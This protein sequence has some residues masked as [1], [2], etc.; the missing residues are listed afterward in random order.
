MRR[1]AAVAA[2]AM[3]LALSGPVP[4]ASAITEPVVD[5]AALPPDGP[6]APPRPMRPLGNCVE[7]GMAPGV[8]VAAPSPSQAMMN[9]VA[10]WSAARSRGARQT[11]ALVDT[12]VTPSPRLRVRGGGD[13]VDKTDG[14]ADCDGHGSAV[15]AIIG[16]APVETDPL[17]GMAPDAD[18]VSIRQSSNA[19]TP[20]Q[21]GG[22]EQEQR[23]GDV[24]TLALAVRHAAD[25][26]GVRVMNISVVACISVLKPVDQTTLG[27]ALRYAHREKDIVI[28][29]AAGNTTNA[30]CGEANPDVDATR[31]KDFRN[32]G[33]V[34]TVSTPAWFKDYVL[35]VGFTAADGSPAKQSLP[36]PWVGVGAPG[37][38]AFGLNGDQI[39]TGRMGNKGLFEPLNGTS[40]AAP[41][42][43]GLAALIRARYP[44]LTASQVVR[45]I[46]ETAH[47]PAQ[48]VD[49]RIGYGVIDPLAALN[50]DATVD[51]PKYPAERLTRSLTPPPP[52]LPKDTRGRTVAL[53][54]FGAI[55]GTLL[56]AGTV[57]I[58]LAGRRKEL[59]DND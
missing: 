56:I 57:A 23:A 28:V 15:A 37:V 27:A 12:G 24:N 29:A 14:M 1:V 41:Y 54:G 16:A 42:V 50:W 46:T 31:G 8:D 20:E 58:V 25:I 22:N 9:P 48:I 39:Y 17:V 7:L 5:P 44:E 36:G 32:W 4:I 35:S 38:A 47:A 3:L 13:Y 33:S 49:N 55:V 59:G 11:I 19:F 51:G 53:S 34:V 10:L 18:L 21:G 52:P 6:P 30:G 40:F 2:A 43:T 45:R 26:P